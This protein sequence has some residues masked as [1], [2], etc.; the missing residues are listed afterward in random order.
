MWLRRALTSKWESEF[1]TTSELKIRLCFPLAGRPPPSCLFELRGTHN[2][3]YQETH[4]PLWLWPKVAPIKWWHD[5]PL[6]KGNCVKVRGCSAP[7]SGLIVSMH[8]RKNRG[9]GHWHDHNW[10]TEL[11]TSTSSQTE[12]LA[13]AQKRGIDYCL[14][15]CREEWY[16]T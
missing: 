12:L 6:W 7:N 2:S 3:G 13:C 11:I 15:K 16:M 8:V 5:E 10:N 14:Q 1:K 4:V 9:E